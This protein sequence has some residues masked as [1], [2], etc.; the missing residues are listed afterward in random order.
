MKVSFFQTYG[1]D[2]QK[3]LEI[4]FRDKR[5]LEFLNFFDINIVSFHNCN[6]E[7]IE[8]FK[9]S[10]NIP[11]LKI[12]INNNVTYTECIKRLLDTF[13]SLKGKFLFFNQDDTFSF[14]NENINFSELLDF[15]FSEEDI[16][17][18]LLME[19]ETFT[20]PHLQLY[21]SLNTIDI[22]SNDSFNFAKHNMW[23]FDDSPYICTSN[24][25]PILYDHNYMSYSDIWSAEHYLNFKFKNQNLKRFVTNK[26]IFKNYNF[27]GPNNWN[28]DYE[29]K[30]LKQKNLL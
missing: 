26:C 24:Y 20:D 9:Q 6:N 11:N 12:F 8:W 17:L 18:N 16:M 4:K 19:K 2:R 29:I 21:K 25:L 23:A 22:Y 3:L 5:L 7:I 13:F 30:T 28:Q 15:I 1:N 27:L 14:N 10:N